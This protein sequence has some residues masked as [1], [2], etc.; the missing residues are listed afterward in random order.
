MRHRNEEEDDFVVK[1][2]GQ[3]AVFVAIIF[4]CSNA[5]AVSF[6]HFSFPFFRLL[7]YTL[8]RNKTL[9]VFFYF[10]LFLFFFWIR[11][12]FFLCSLLLFFSR[13]GSEDDGE[14]SASGA[15]TETERERENVHI[16]ARK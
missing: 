16:Y 9:N 14:R 10:S 5:P 2:T 1:S 6:C 3:R 12:F 4:V 13:V 8:I 15:L 7:L 11:H